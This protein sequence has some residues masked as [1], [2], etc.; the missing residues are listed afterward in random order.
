MVIDTRVNPLPSFYPLNLFYSLLFFNGDNIRGILSSHDNE[1]FPHGLSSS[2][3]MIY[4]ITHL[5]GN[6]TQ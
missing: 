4:E 1:E 3:I 6:E 2:F 5:A